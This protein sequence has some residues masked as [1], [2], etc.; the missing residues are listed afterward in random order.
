MAQ[1]TRSSTPPPPPARMLAGQARAAGGDPGQLARGDSRRGRPQVAQSR[2][3][4]PRTLDEMYGHLGKW[5]N[6][7]PASGADEPSGK[8]WRSISGELA[9]IMRHDK[10]CKHFVDGRVYHERLV[11]VLKPRH[12]FLATTTPWGLCTL[13][14]P[15]PDQGALSVLVRARVPGPARGVRA[16]GSARAQRRHPPRL[17][18]VGLG[19]R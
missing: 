18:Q 17:A 6:L 14:R 19:A 10:V 11:A 9:R 16:A 2:C 4:P 7:G 13:P 1:W 12:P 15:A 3:E 5:H 8:V